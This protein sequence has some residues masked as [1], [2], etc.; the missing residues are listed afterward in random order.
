MSSDHPRPWERRSNRTYLPD[1]RVITVIWV[2]ITATLTFW[3]L[4]FAIAVLPFILLVGGCVAI[5]LPGIS[6]TPGPAS[7]QESLARTESARK[8][9]K[10]IRCPKCDETF[11]R[12]NCA[13]GEKIK[14]PQCEA[15]LLVPSNTR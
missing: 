10:S 1:P 12:G 13:P 9:T 8:S 11:P 6:Q 7:Q 14:C 4:T 3:A 2:A 5:S 15:S